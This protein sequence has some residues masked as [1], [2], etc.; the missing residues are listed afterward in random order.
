MTK[1]LKLLGCPCCG[2]KAFWF[3]GDDNTRMEDRV[4]CLECF[5][6]VAG[7]Y[8][9]QSALE[10][11]NWRVLSHCIQNREVNVEGENL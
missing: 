10:K 4:Q 2:A 1:K 7:D 3:K 9:P 8:T 5:L 6:E 11:W